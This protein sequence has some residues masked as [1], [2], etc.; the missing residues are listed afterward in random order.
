MLVID[1]I[2]GILSAREGDSNSNWRKGVVTE[3]LAQMDG[4]EQLNNIL[5]IGMTHRLEDLDEGVVR[6]GRFGY[7]IAFELPDADSRKEIL[8][9]HCKKMIEQSKFAGVIDFDEL[10]EKTKGMSGADICELVKLAGGYGVERL[11]DLDM[12]GKDLAVDFKEGLVSM[13]DF[14]RAIEEHKTLQG[15]VAARESPA[16]MYM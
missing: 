4:L 10:A 8:Q 3:F 5:V 6:S 12:L 11:M 15:N 1:E 16:S 13:K 7:K 2:D 9:I 14:R